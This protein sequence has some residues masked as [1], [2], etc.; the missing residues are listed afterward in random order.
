MTTP[1]KWPH[2]RCRPIAAARDELVAALDGLTHFGRSAQDVSISTGYMSA[3]LA[4]NKQSYDHA[5]DMC[6]EVRDRLLALAPGNV[7]AREWLD[8]VERT[9]NEESGKNERDVRHPD[10]G[11]GSE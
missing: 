6:R 1:K 7:R 2:T 5:R 3:S 10:G 8:I 4:K 11:G 9:A